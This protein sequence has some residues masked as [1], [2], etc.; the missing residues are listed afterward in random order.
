MKENKKEKKQIKIS[1]GT[2]ICMVIIEILSVVLVGIIVYCDY[3]IDKMK[4]SYKEEVFIENKTI[5]KVDN[6]A[7]E[8]KKT[9]NETKQN[10]EE[11]NKAEISKMYIGK[12][13]SQYAVDLQGEKVD[14]S[15]L[16]GSGYASYGSKLILN[17]DGT[18]VNEIQ[19]I[20]SNEFSNTG[21]W[22]YKENLEFSEMIGVGVILKYTDGRE[23]KLQIWASGEADALLFYQYDE[24]NQIHLMK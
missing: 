20:Q 9:E 16:L 4:E 8:D 7:D 11:N 3:K 6:I 17:E 19:P 14:L 5:D 12:W 10:T 23:E 1:L 2:A 24:E 15:N 18:F 13:N 21:T 22:E